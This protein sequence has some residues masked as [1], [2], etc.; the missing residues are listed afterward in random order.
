M[1]EKKSKATN[2]KNS[3]SSEEIK[4][5]KQQEMKLPI[6]RKYLLPVLAIIVLMGIGAFLLSK[7]MV[8]A[9]VNGESI[10]RAEYT[11]E[12]EKTA[13]KQVLEGLT[14]KKIIE[15]EAKKKNVSV[16]SQEIDTEIKKLDDQLKSQGQSL[17]QILSFQGLNREGLREQIM[18][19]KTVEKLVGSDVKVSTQEVDTYIEQNSELAGENTDLDELKKKAEEQLK[20]Q[21][22]DTKIQE[23]IQNLRKNAK[24]EYY[25]E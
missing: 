25:N 15:Q 16:S 5:E 9:N 12:L 22:I 19:Q 2:P 6:S 13:G 23:L 10:S 17:D 8:V 20:Q 14:T 4:A 3:S 24:I 11:Q 1:P 21:K 7:W 18:I